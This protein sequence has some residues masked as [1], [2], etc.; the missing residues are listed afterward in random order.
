MPSCI[1]SRSK[2]ALG[3]VAQGCVPSCLLS[4][5][6]W[7]LWHRGVCHP[8]SY[9]GLNGHWVLWHRGVCHP[10]PYPGLNGL[11]VLWHRGVCHP[12]SYPGLNG[13]CVL[14][15]DRSLG[16]GRVRKGMVSVDHDEKGNSGCCWLHHV[17]QGWTVCNAVCVCVWFQVRVRTNATGH[18]VYG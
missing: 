4:R 10:V 8:V 9:P 15:E 17:R 12:V 11:W 6:K 7:V 14:C 3:A 5:S 2:W 13:L 18:S 16:D 1:L